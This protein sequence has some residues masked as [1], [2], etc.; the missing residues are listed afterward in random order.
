MTH[1]PRV[2]AVIPFYGEPEP[3]LAI[4]D[5]LRAQQGIDPTDIEIIVS[6]DVSPTPFPEVEGV[7]VVRRP[8]N[9]GFGKAVNSGVAAATGEWV[10]ILNSDLELDNSFVSRMLAAVERHGEILASPQIIGHDG[11]QQWVA[12]K[13][14]TAAHVAWEWFDYGQTLALLPM[15]D[16]PVTGEHRASTVLTLPHQRIEPLLTMDEAAFGE[17]MSRRYHGRLGRMQLTSTR[18][19]YP[20]VGVMPHRLVSR[21]FACVGDAA[22][23]MH[24][25]T[26]HGFNFGLLSIDT[27]AEELR[28]AHASGKDIGSPDLLARYERRHMLATRP[29]YE[30]TK[31]IATLYTTEAAPAKLLRNAALHL[32]QRFTPFRKLVAASLTGSL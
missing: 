10:F 29:L 19:S 17:E 2:S 21:R 24:P 14:P 12:R 28:T 13:F 11:K 7:T 9:G 32:G 3:V 6:D 25:V 18:H 31:L 15:N 30:V 5:T 16:D 1:T 4:I 8:V 22:V 27:L 26:A 20:L 23:G